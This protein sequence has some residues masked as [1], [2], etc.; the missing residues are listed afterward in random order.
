[1]SSMSQMM[2]AAAVEGKAHL[3]NSRGQESF[4]PKWV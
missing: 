2:F 1:M 3:I 4:L